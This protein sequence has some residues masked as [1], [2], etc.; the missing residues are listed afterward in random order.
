M[1]LKVRAGDVFDGTYVIERLLGSGGMGAVFVADEVRLGRKVAIKVLSGDANVPAEVLARFGR[2][3]RAIA[4]LQSD[5]AARIY[6]VGRRDDG[7]PYIVME[8]LEGEDLEAVI[9]RGG[10]V[11]ARELR[12]YAIQACDALAEAHLLGIVHRDIK[13]A[14][15][16]LARK[17]TG[18]VTLK[19]IDFGISKGGAREEVR[20]TRSRQSLGTPLYMSPEQ[21]RASKAIDGRTD[22][23][24]L[25]VVM[26]ELLTGVSPFLADDVPAVYA[27]VLELHP[28]APS[29]LTG[30]KDSD[31]D[32]IILR[33]MAKDVESRFASAGDL[34][35][36]L[37]LAENATRHESV[38]VRSHSASRLRSADDSGSAR[39][40]RESGPTDVLAPTIA[41]VERA[42]DEKPAAPV[43]AERP[44][45][46]PPEVAAQAPVLGRRTAPE[47]SSPGRPLVAAGL[48][49]AF[50]GAAWLVWFRHGEV[51][52]ATSVDT[53]VD[54]SARRAIQPPAGELVAPLLLGGS[55]REPV[56]PAIVSPLP[57]PTRLSP[58]A[59][60]L[61]P[62]APAH[63][64]P[65]KTAGTAVTAHNNSEP[66]SLM[67]TTRF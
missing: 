14:N 19:V 60:A 22:I 55:R 48:L 44:D 20:L 35:A 31:L 23:W 43:P 46:T 15:L 58:A 13:P 7:C 5:H 8:H 10:A 64:A 26:Y 62:S 66:P 47:R 50:M 21:V 16:F 34:A 3:A 2:E 27:N 53:E 33:C 45:R 61:K 37:T 4:A 65:T 9:E 24:S 63:A 52:T 56:E 29:E 17:P 57:A 32:A 30:R 25:G 11:D 18:A 36:A 51:S 42:G 28:P 54:A 39:L 38:P 1:A 59:P 49:F 41:Q 67:P 12:S 40:A 6:N